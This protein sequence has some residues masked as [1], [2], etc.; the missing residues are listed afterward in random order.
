MPVTQAAFSMLEVL[1]PMLH[2]LFPLLGLPL[3]FFAAGHIIKIFKNAIGDDYVSTSN[4]SKS[5]PKEDIYFDARKNGYWVKMSDGSR[6]FVGMNDLYPND[7]DIQ[8]QTAKAQPGKYIWDSVN[9][10]F[11]ER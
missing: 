2:L 3:F 4:V 1:K 11:K 7:V 9:M 5:E 6:S 8:F 10:K